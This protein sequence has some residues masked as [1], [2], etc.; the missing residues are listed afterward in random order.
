MPGVPIKLAGG[1][2]EPSVDEGPTPC[3]SAP[4]EK[5]LLGAGLI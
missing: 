1:G 4:A 5:L 2:L 3:C